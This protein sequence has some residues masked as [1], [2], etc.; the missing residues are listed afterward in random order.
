MLCKS[1]IIYI[2]RAYVI[3][4]LFFIHGCLSLHF[5][6]TTYNKWSCCSNSDFAHMFNALGKHFCLKEAV[7][8]PGKDYNFLLTFSPIFATGN[9]R[10][11]CT[12]TALHIHD[13]N[14]HNFK[15]LC[16]YIVCKVNYGYFKQ[17]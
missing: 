7:H 1:D 6:Q 3:G 15:C 2:H 4:N 13:N 5:F 9:W 12:R 10:S 16:N 11:N 17:T 8:L 14:G